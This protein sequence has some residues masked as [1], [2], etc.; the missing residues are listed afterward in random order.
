M[1]ENMIAHQEHNPET[2]FI[3]NETLNSYEEKIKS[4]LSEL[5]LKVF[6]C[7]L[8]RMSYL[9]ISNHLNINKKAV[10]NAVQRIKKK[11]ETVLI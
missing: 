6:E 1:I 4:A 5:E 8:G 7:Y 3:S 11:L 2:I 9:D 10:D